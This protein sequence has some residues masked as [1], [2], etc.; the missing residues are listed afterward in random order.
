MFKNFVLIKDSE[1]EFLK[2]IEDF[3]KD[4]NSLWKLPNLFIPIAAILLAILC[5]LAFSD[6]RWE[7]LNYL[8][9]IVNGSLPLIAINQISGLSVHIF[10]YDKSVEK[11]FETNTFM[12]RTKLFWSSISILI[13]GVLLFAFQV[14]SNPF[15]NF[16]LLII[17]FLLSACLVWFSSYVSRRLYLLQEDFI[18][19]TFDSEIRKEAEEKH[20]NNWG[21]KK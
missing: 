3:H 9:L 19:R 11:K 10:K 17:M 5:Y 13:F 20:G 18:E 8:N 12:L 6:N 21:K 14:I 7:F 2:A 16:I 15:N 1:K 4:D